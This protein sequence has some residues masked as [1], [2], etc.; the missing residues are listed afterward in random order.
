MARM[1]PGLNE[2][3]S[4][5][6]RFVLRSARLSLS[7]APKPPPASAATPL[8]ENWSVGPARVISNPA[9]SGR[10]PTSPLAFRKDRSSIGPDGGTPTHQ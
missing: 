8:Y 2:K 5:P 4:A 10:L 6:S 9:A 7:S 1:S 3:A